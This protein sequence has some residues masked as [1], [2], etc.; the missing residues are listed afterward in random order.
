MPINLPFMCPPPPTH[1]DLKARARLACG[2]CPGPGLTPAG[3]LPGSQPGVPPNWAAHGTLESTP[4]PEGSTT[5]PPVPAPGAAQ[6]KHDQLGHSHSRNHALG[7]VLSASSS[8]WGLQASWA[9]GHITPACPSIF[10][11]PF[12]FFFFKIYLFTFIFGLTGSSLL[13]I[14]F[15]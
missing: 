9:C 1:T 7:R 10:T 13:Y 8:S 3:S 5:G 6:T 12:L 11:L 14:G 2:A 4:A 15:L